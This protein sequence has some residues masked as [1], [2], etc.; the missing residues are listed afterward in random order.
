MNKTI[1]VVA[2]HPDDEAIGCAGSIARHVD[3][4]DHIH[5][6]FMSSGEGS[7]L[8]DTDSSAKSRVTSMENAAK[9]LGLQST[10][11]LNF[12]DNKMDSIPLLDIVQALELVF[13]KVRPQ[14]VYTHHS[15]DLNVDHRRTHEAV[16]T[17]CRPLP[18]SSVEEILAFE[19]LSSTEWQSPVITPFV[20]N[21]YVDIS[22]FIEKKK[23]AINA[24][25]SEMREPPHSRC[26]DH[27][28]ALARHRGLSV[29]FEF[30]EAFFL[31]RKIRP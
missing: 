3:D 10:T 22:A 19:V 27:I 11:C 8:A 9:L 17:A 29:G 12:P 2:A 18:G 1:A 31:V 13:E 30:A 24:Y 21:V 28:I 16:I 20:P 23:L 14:L 5:A 4:G 7:R 25:K 6:I 15:G 26:K